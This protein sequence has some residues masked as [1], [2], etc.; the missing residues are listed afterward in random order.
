MK[1][2]NL[3][4]SQELQPFTKQCN[5]MWNELQTILLQVELIKKIRVYH[6]LV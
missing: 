6:F 3:K 2:H 1:S 5:H 4:N